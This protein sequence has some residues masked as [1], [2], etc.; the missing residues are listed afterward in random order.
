MSDLRVGRIS[1]LNMFPIYHHLDAARLPGIT[2][3]DG[4]PALLNAGV[5]AG[6]GTAWGVSVTQTFEWPGRI[7]L[8]KALA[9]QQVELAELGLARY[10]AALSAAG[11]PHHLEAAVLV[12]RGVFHGD[13]VVSHALGEVEHRLLPVHRGGGGVGG[14][15]RSVAAFERGDAAG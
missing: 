10:R 7:A 3:T 6:E 14:G 1:A 9:N 2:F 4:L 15:R 11:R 8:R 13:A 12:R 5:L